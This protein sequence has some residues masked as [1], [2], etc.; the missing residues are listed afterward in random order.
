MQHLDKT[1]AT[2][3]MKALTATRLKYSL[4]QLKSLEHTL[5][6]GVKHMQHPNKKRL[7]KYV[8]NTDEIFEQALAICLLN[9]CNIS[10]YFCNIHMK[11]LQHTYE[12]SETLEK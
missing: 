5:A 7:Q 8:S 9:T 2:C 10:I 3:N 1:L 11:H 4:E 12:T 6:T